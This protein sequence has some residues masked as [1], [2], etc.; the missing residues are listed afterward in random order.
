MYAAGLAGTW[1]DADGCEAFGNTPGA[2]VLALR[3]AEPLNP[4]IRR[5]REHTLSPG[6]Y[7]YAGSAY[8]SGGIAARL[9]RHFRKDKKPHWHIDRLTLAAK[10]M[11]ALAVPGGNECD[12]VAAM[13]ET[14]QVQIPVPG[15]GS[16]DCKICQSHLLAIA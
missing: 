12:L 15:F 4:N 14:G 10:E 5:L 1:V 3:L 11:R 9:K 7:V 2:Y 13:L 16:S 6:N 8:G